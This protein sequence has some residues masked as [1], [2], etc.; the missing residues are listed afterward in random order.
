MDTINYFTAESDLPLQDSNNAYGAISSSQYRVTSLFTGGNKPMAYAVTNGEVFIVDQIGNPMRVNLF[1][2]PNDMPFGVPV[3]YFAYRGLLKSD[4]LDEDNAYDGI[5]P[6][7]PDDSE[8][9]KNLR[10]GQNPEIALSLYT[11]LADGYYID[12]LF[13]T[14]QFQFGLVKQG[15][16]IGRFDALLNYGFEIM[17]QDTFFLPNLGIARKDTNIIE[18]STVSG[19]AEVSRLQI[20][21][22]IDPAAY[23]GLFVH[24]KFSVGTNNSASPLSRTKD[25]LYQF[26]KKFYTKNL[27]YIDIRDVY[28]QP[29]DWLENRPQTIKIT[30]NGSPAISSSAVSYR[31]TNNFPIKTVANGFSNPSTSDNGQKYFT[32]KVSL[33][34]SGITTPI[35]ALQGG[36]WL[37]FVSEIVDDMIFSV[38]STDNP[39]WSDDKEFAIFGINDNNLSVPIATYVR[40][41]LSEYIDINV[42][43]NQIPDPSDVVDQANFNI[44]GMF[45][46]PISGI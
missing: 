41:E 23:Y 6:M 39:A 9:I 10:K 46:F 45:A 20:L 27:V 19:E 2:K 26:I 37:R 31:A 7:S 34:I 21:N 28:E 25:G 29:L 24:S 42:I 32:L 18:V 30:T 11:D 4:F 8:L 38:C 16:S 1:L 35:L 33:P 44:R 13:V 14:A 40:L 22:Y 43:N 15:D 36:Y 17:L 12:D 5:R 3:K